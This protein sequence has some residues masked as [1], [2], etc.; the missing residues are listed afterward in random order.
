MT[1]EKITDWI[2]DYPYDPDKATSEIPMKVVDE[3]PD[4]D[5]DDETVYLTKETYETLS[6]L[7]EERGICLMHVINAILYRE[8]V[9]Q[10]SGAV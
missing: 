9:E 5:P 1:K 2:S 3:L 8:L 7:A 4:Q 6:T 10:S